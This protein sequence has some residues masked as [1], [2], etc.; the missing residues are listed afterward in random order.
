MKALSVLQ[1]WAQLLVL[2]VKKYETRSWK[3]RHRGPVLIHA[4]QRFPDSA[5]RLCETFHVALAQG[6][7]LFPADLPLGSLVGTVYLE[8]CLPADQVLYEQPSEIE[9]A[10]GDFRPGHWAWKMS[11]AKRLATPIPY[12]GALGI[13]KVVSV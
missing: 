7:I 12:Q 5:R 3:T 2:G 4:S 9:L 6:G 11:N 10:L 1:P 8:D 13:F